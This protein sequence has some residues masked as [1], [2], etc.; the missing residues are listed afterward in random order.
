MRARR[1]AA[2]DGRPHPVP[3][4]PASGRGPQ[5]PVGGGSAFPLTLLPLPCYCA[6]VRSCPI[7]HFDGFPGHFS[8]RSMSRGLAEMSERIAHVT[9]V[10]D[11]KTLDLQMPVEPSDRAAVQATVHTA[12]TKGFLARGSPSPNPNI[13]PAFSNLLFFRKGKVSKCVGCR[14]PSQPYFLGVQN[15]C[16]TR[17]QQQQR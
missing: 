7:C 5:V 17:D 1:L 16:Q 11:Q 10:M 2:G 3:P 8:E 13:S 9:S 14:D 6:D 15:R 12:L 4:S